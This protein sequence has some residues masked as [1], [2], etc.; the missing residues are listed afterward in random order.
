[1]T[2]NNGRYFLNGKFTVATI[3]LNICGLSIQQIYETSLVFNTYFQENISLS[4]LITL[5]SLKTID[6]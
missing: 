1:M 6:T 3:K 2:D 5:K 4:L